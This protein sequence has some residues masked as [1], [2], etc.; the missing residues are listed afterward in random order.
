[1]V[2]AKTVKGGRNL[3]RV[4]PSSKR[5]D[6]NGEAVFTI[7]AKNKTGNATVTFKDG[8][9]STQVSVTVVK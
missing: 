9:L 1:M 2:K 4:T 7:T 3:I 8:S 6:A 5:T